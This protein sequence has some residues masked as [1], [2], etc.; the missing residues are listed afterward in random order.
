LRV[1]IWDHEREFQPVR[2]T[3]SLR[4]RPFDGTLDSLAI[5]RWITDEWPKSPHIPLLETRLRELMQF[6]FAFDPRIEWVDI[7]LSKPWACREARGVGVRMALSRDEYERM[8]G[9]RALTQT[10]ANA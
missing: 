4:A 2:V 6:V 8:F 3:L 9:P 1:G 7:A 10:S 5:P